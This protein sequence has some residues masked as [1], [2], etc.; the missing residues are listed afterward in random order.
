MFSR[1]HAWVLFA[2]SD[3]SYRAHTGL[4]AVKADELLREFDRRF[5]HHNV[6]GWVEITE[7]PKEVEGSPHV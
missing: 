3:M 7:P 2:A 4:A 6:N 5:Q 1:A